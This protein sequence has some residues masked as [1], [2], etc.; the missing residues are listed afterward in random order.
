VEGE[1]AMGRIM[2]ALL[3]CAILMGKATADEKKDESSDRAQVTKFLKEH[4]IDKTVASPKETTKQDE[5]RMESDAEDQTTFN[6]F[7]ESAQGFGFDM[8]VVNKERRYE[9]GKDG[10]RILPGRDLSGTEVYRYEII[11]RVSTKKLTGSVR[12]LSMTTKVP[13]RA[14]ASILVTGVKVVDGKL[15]WN[16]TLPG[17]LDLIAAGG[18]YKPGSWDGKYTFSLDGGKLQFQAEY[19]NFDVDPDTLKRTPTKDKLP[20]FVSKEIGK[21]H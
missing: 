20:A 3:A 17:Y 15:T 18:K 10:K 16:E 8:T 9:I 2:L 19:T 11:E 4:V 5:G 21:G 1:A 7:T 12:F 13:S 6:N 14:G